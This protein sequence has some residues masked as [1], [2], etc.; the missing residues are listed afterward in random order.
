MDK[1]YK[2]LHEGAVSSASARDGLEL[3]N[4][5]WWHNDSSQWPVFP[6][7]IEETR[8]SQKSPPVKMKHRWLVVAFIIDG[9]HSYDFASSQ[10]IIEP[11]DICVIP[12][13]F[14]YT[15]SSFSSYHKLVILFDGKLL[16]QT[17]QVLNLE[18]PFKLTLPDAKKEI[19]E[20]LALMNDYSKDNT[21]EIL[22]II[23]KLLTEISILATVQ[24]S[25]PEHKL[26]AKIKKRLGHNLEDKI[27]LRDIVM[28]FNISHSLLHKIFMKYSSTSPK[29]YRIARKME[30]AC[31]CLVYT[32][33]SI[34]E[35]AFQVGYN[36][37]HYFSNDF[38]K[39][40]GM[41]PRNYRYIAKSNNPH[42][43]NSS[44]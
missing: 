32:D 42:A 14:E 1:M 36:N 16:M 11:G 2:K 41:S 3:Y 44:A 20:I 10:I 24:D 6:L 7:I 15:F 26:F 43:I 25:S 39:H 4:L 5:S 18:E 33:Q 22:G 29:Q 19:R 34:K 9:V 31:H 13:H 37:Q 12:P 30:R 21:S 23:N 40:H 38:K 8:R 28:E 35:I 17:C 27:T